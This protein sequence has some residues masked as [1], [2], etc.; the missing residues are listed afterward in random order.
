MA[1]P[2]GTG[3]RSGSR[4]QS[5]ERELLWKKRNSPKLPGSIM[6]RHKAAFALLFFAA[7]LAAQVRDG[8]PVTLLASVTDERGRFVDDLRMQDFELR[9]DGKDQAITDFKTFRNTASS[10]GVLVDVSASMKNRLTDATN[11]IDE[12]LGDLHR[13]KHWGCRKLLLPPAENAFSDAIPAGH[14]GGAH[15]G[16][17]GFFQEPRLVGVAEPSPVSFARPWHDR[18]FSMRSGTRPRT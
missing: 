15:T 2:A 17:R 9:E 14:V 16:A 13:D 6:F 18:L 3:S 8:K 1:S 10:V 12:F 5:P 4:A 11:A 7:I